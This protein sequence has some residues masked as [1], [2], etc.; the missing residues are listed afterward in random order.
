MLSGRPSRARHAQLLAARLR[1]DC[2]SAGT[3]VPS[4]RRAMGNASRIPCEWQQR[5]VT[6]RCLADDVQRARLGFDAQ[7]RGVSAREQGAP[8]FLRA[9]LCRTE[10]CGPARGATDCGAD[11]VDHGAV[12]RIRTR[13]HQQRRLAESRPDG[14]VERSGGHALREL[15]AA[16]HRE[17]GAEGLSLVA[18]FHVTHIGRQHAVRE[19]REERAR[20]GAHNRRAARRSRECLPVNLRAAR[21]RSTALQPWR[22]RRVLPVPV[23]APAQPLAPVVPAPSKAVVA[24]GPR[25][26]QPGFQRAVATRACGLCDAHRVHDQAQCHPDGDDGDADIRPARDGREREDGEVRVAARGD[27]AE[28]AVEALPHMHVHPEHP[29]EQPFFP[30]AAAHSRRG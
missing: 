26:R 20:P 21:S 29:D 3:S 5:R 13:P 7:L 1:C 30:P 23:R 18:E 8:E 28:F 19:S 4:S 14:G 15:R 9:A 25:S 24:A 10:S 27:Q 2:E 22:C 12:I 11:E 17:L 6:L 16:Q